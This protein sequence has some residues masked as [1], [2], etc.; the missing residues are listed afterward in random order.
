SRR[1]GELPRAYL[2]LQSPPPWFPSAAALLRLRPQ[3]DTSHGVLRQFL[4]LASTPPCLRFRLRLSLESCCSPAAVSRRGLRDCS[5]PLA[6]KNA[7]TVVFAPEVR[8][9]L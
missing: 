4:L 3:S 6:H 9:I 1:R 2:V 5:I 7:I 8:T